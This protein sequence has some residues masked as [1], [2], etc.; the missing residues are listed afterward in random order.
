MRVIFHK[1]F[2]CF[3]AGL[4]DRKEYRW[5][6]SISVPCQLISEASTFLDHSKKSNKNG[7]RWGMVT[8]Q[9]FIHVEI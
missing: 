9:E 4:N 5:T 3:T 1:E 8:D 2:Y 7:R 6:W